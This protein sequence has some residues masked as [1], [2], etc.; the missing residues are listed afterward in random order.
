MVKI[1]VENLKAL[2][3]ALCVAQ[4][5]ISQAYGGRSGEYT[6]GKVSRIGEIIDQID[7]LRPLGPNGKHGN[8]HTEFCG[9]E[10]NPYLELLN[11]WRKIPEFPWFELNGRGDIR[12]A[13]DLDYRTQEKL[14]ENIWVQEVI[15]GEKEYH[16]TGWSR[17]GRYLE[18]M[19]VPVS[20][21]IKNAFPDLA[22]YGTT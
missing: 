7:T 19:M 2:R 3:E 20:Y 18:S 12:F 10:D 1:E 6:K 11:T 22:V 9:C 15:P 13:S 14:G 8:R 21:L 5:A 17:D 4:S 16:L